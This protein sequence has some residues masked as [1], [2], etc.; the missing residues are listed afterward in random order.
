ME[1]NKLPAEIQYHRNRLSKAEAELNQIHAVYN[2][3][4]TELTRIIEIAG[5]T[6]YMISK[7]E[8]STILSILIKNSKEAI[9]D[10]EFKNQKLEEVWGKVN[11]KS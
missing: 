7:A 11:G 6:A 8:Q 3:S 10:L 1:Y 2:C 5:D 9:A 4:E